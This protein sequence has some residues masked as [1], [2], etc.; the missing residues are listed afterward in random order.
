MAQEE[1]NF[2]SKAF[3]IIAAE[4]PQFFTQ[5]NTPFLGKD[6]EGSVMKQDIGSDEK[7]INESLLSLA[8]LMAPVGA[9]AGVLGRAAMAAPRLTGAAASAG[10][11]AVTKDPLDIVPGKL[12]AVIGS[13]G[14]AEAMII[15][16]AKIHPAEAIKNALLLKNTLQ[17]SGIDAYNAGLKAYNKTGIYEGLLDNVPRAVVSDQ[18]VSLF[19]KE[20]GTLNDILYHPELFKAMPELKDMKVEHFTPEDAK[21]M[22]GGYYPGENKIGIDPNLNPQEFIS[23]LL[24]ETQHAIQNNNKMITGGSPRLEETSNRFAETYDNAIKQVPNIDQKT[25]TNL[26]QTIRRGLYEQGAGEAEARAVQNMWEDGNYTDYPL[27]VKDGR[28]VNYDIPL[29]R[30]IKPAT[31]MFQEF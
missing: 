16:A 31:E 6:Q 11:F 19:S 29:D 22:K 15:P 10:T 3:R 2:L 18:K 30:V 1:E 13:S 28:S 24:H 20:A 21:V 12:G 14:D 9:T 25:R 17:E 26:Y 4:L 5:T 7:K 23:V 8:A 27:R